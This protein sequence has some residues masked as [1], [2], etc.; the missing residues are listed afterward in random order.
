MKPQVR[1]QVGSNDIKRARRELLSTNLEVRRT[2]NPRGWRTLYDFLYPLCFE[3]SPIRLDIVI[4]EADLLPA[5]NRIFG[6]RTA[7]FLRLRW[8][9]VL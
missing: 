2:G 9:L 7:P 5:G 6:A 1:E 3:A 8:K 4:G